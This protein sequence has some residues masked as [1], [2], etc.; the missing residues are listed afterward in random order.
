MKILVIGAAGMIGRKLTQ[1]ILDQGGIGGGRVDHMLLA[2]VIE[3]VVPAGAPATALA[4]DLGDPGTAAR[5]LADRPDVIFHLAAVVSG[6][7]EVDFEKGYRVNLD[8]TRALLETIRTTPDY[9]PRLV[10]ASSLAV[11]G[12]PF[13]ARIPDDFAPTP[14]TSYGIQKLM[15]ESLISDYSR[16]GMV[17]GVSLRL[18][19][20]CIRPGKPN[21]AASGFFS[22]ILREPLIGQEA[23]LPVPDSVRHWFA[24][25]R[26]ATGFFLHAATM[27]LAPLDH[28]RALN[29]PGLSATVAEQIEALRAVAGQA[30]V[31]LIRPE[32]DALVAGIVEGWASDYD[33]TRAHA[34]GFAAETDFQQIIRAHIEDELDNQAS[35]SG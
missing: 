3:P 31:D 20:I 19:T 33:A 2:D 6:E 30:A 21:R 24:S 32:P 10:F 25:P 16:K 28:R 23:V 11:F 5:L 29:M 9:M 27:D 1:A 7:A 35:I 8:G 4:V 17:E 34:L 14:R 18:P 12:P 15:A 26:S 13:P 22:G